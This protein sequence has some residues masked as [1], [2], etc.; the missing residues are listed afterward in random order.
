MAHCS[1]G[2][3]QPA[4]NHG[5]GGQATGNWRAHAAFAVGKEATLAAMATGN[6]RLTPGDR[7]EILAAALRALHTAPAPRA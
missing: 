2:A 4:R 3:I 5:V 6:G 7:D 1:G